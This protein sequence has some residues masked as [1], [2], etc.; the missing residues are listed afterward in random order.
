MCQQVLKLNLEFVPEIYHSLN[1]TTLHQS[2]YWYTWLWIFGEIKD[3]KTERK[4]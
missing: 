1:Y 3:I 4:Y 2:W